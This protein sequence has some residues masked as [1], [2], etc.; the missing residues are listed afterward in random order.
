MLVSKGLSG[1]V[2]PML[3]IILYFA[4]ISWT[5]PPIEDR[6]VIKIS[7]LNVLTSSLSDKKENILAFPKYQWKNRQKA[8]IQL[9]QLDRP[10]VLGLCELDINQA[11][12]LEMELEEYILVGFAS[13][14]GESIETTK[15]RFAHEEHR[16]YGEFVALLVDK[17]RIRIDELKCHIL[18]SAKKQKW[19]R[20]IVEASLYDDWTDT[21]FVCLASH[22]DHIKK[23]VHVRKQSA[24]QELA[25]LK[26]LEE[27]KIPWFSVGDRNWYVNRD[28]ENANIYL[29]EP[30]ISDFRDR[31]ELGHFGPS[32]TFPGYLW[33]CR[34]L[35]P[36]SQVPTVDTGYRSA[37]LIEGIY[38]YAYTGE[39]DPVTGNLLPIHPK[40]EA[41]GERNL[42]SDHYLFGGAFRFKK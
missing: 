16:K 18:P 40:S 20:I 30:F 32:G 12:T 39:F 29:Q 41:L 6:K 27:E 7:F 25:I 5:P 4:A 10:A 1:I 8:L 31:M 17:S 42:L 3:G 34:F 33:L 21:S 14:T 22:F 2:F 13:E 38:Y 19:Q 11:K 9:I 24:E 28:E 36:P 15:M 26:R 35:P 23:S 37:Y